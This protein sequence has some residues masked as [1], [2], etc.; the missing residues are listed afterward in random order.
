MK[1]MKVG[2]WTLTDNVLGFN[3]SNI[4]T[5]IPMTK[6]RLQD[7]QYLLNA[8]SKLTEPKLVGY[9]LEV[10]GNYFDFNGMLF[11]YQIFKS[12]TQIQEWLTAYGIVSGLD[13][14]SVVKVIPIYEDDIE[15]YIYVGDVDKTATEYCPHCDEEV[16]LSNT[17]IPQVCPN[18]GKT[19]LPC[20]M[21]NECKNC[22]FQSKQ[23][24]SHYFKNWIF[25]INSLTFSL[26]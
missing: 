23:C 20:N 6:E 14:N 11:S 4:A 9:Q 5:C 15:E 18:C 26:E 19:I 25:N 24:S 8:N 17:F 7:L 21:C 16:E 3:N 1:I 12:H 13:E 10:G 2:D 22:P